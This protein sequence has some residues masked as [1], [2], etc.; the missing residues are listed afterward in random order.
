MG[1]D[2]KVMASHFRELRGELL[3][4]ATVRFERDHQLLAQLAPDA[5]PALARPLP[6]G[7]KVGSYEDGGLTFVETDRHGQPL[8]FVTPTDLRR[9]V[10]PEDITPWNAA[11]LAFLLALPRDTR[12]VLYWC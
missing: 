2:L 12:I 10:V 7:L 5:T 1:I 9:L 8:T 3:P 11:V 4:T 6:Q